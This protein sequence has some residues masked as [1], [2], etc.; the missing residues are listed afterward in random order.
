[1]SVEPSGKGSGGPVREEIYWAMTLPVNE[2]SSILQATTKRE[3]VHRKNLRD[4]ELPC[5]PGLSQT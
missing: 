5:R 3:I 4:L 1:M 2:E